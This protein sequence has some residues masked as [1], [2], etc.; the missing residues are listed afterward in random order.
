MR[1]IH[2]TCVR[3]LQNPVEGC[4]RLICMGGFLLVCEDAIKFMSFRQVYG[5]HLKCNDHMF[6]QNM[7]FAV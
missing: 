6:T 1:D 4:E 2:L 7:P 5:G 3:S